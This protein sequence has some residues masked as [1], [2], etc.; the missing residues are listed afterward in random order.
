MGVCEQFGQNTGKGINI[1]DYNDF[2]PVSDLIAGYGEYSKGSPELVQKAGSPHY[3]DSKLFKV[4][5]YD[6]YI[7]EPNNE[8]FMV[9]TS[10]GY[11][12]KFDPIIGWSV[13]IKDATELPR[14]PLDFKLSKSQK[15]LLAVISRNTDLNEYVRNLREVVGDMV[16]DTSGNI[17]VEM[18]TRVLELYGEAV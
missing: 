8:W 1:A 6:D 12:E 18:Q 9:Q 7:I 14:V 15:E 5:V 2:R 16:E 11:G 10:G 4:S 13:Y 3:E 17:I